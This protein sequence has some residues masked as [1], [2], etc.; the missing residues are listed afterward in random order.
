MTTALR[1]DEQPARFRYSLVI[2]TLH[3]DGEL[4][5]CLAS[6]T[7]LHH[8]PDFEV[9]VVDQNGD[10]RLDDLV[11]R[12]SGKLS[13]THLKVA[14]RCASQAR[15]LGVAHARGAWV[16]FPDDDCQLLPD[17][18]L[19]VE[20][21]S[22]D[23]LVCVI[24]GQTVDAAG[25]PNLLRWKKTPSEFSRWSMFGRVTEATL[26]VRRDAFLQAGGFDER[27]GPGTTFPAAEGV[28]LLNRL[29]AGMGQDKAYYSPQVRMQHPT[30][31][32][33][34]NRWVVARFHAYARGAGA[35]VAKHPAPHMLVW[36]VRIIV[37]A[38]VQALIF[39][40]WRGAAFAARLRGF[41]EGLHAGVRAFHGR[42]GR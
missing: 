18:L 15:N 21:L 41:F 7:A 36:G 8:G 4:G 1:P 37:G 17:T 20:R 16:G 25:A 14:F 22:A 33:P 32:P 6:C 26:F 38:A 23:P 2:A 27:F 28:D 12:F 13:I 11:R 19:E 31:V 3:D 10:D 42:S 24:S 35:L 5:D 40:G 30:K 34:W 29:F 9:V 39:R